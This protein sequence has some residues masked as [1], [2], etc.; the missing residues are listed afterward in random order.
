MSEDS[1]EK[2]D[3]QAFTLELDPAVQNSFTSILPTPEDEVK[4]FVEDIAEFEI[5]EKE[6]D[7]ETVNT[8]DSKEK[9]IVEIEKEIG[10]DKNGE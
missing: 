1:P 4:D 10:K 7:T 6:K 3:S 2:R 9:E 5:I 8:P